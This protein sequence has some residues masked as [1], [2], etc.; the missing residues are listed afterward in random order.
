M[1]LALLMLFSAFTACDSSEQ[2]SSTE[3]AGSSETE[4]VLVT[5][6]ETETET[7]YFPN[8]A[9]NNYDADFFLSVQPDS[10]Y[11]EYHW[12]EESSNDVLSQAIYDRQQ[13]V[14][15]YLG[16]EI[17]GT[18]TETSKNYVDPFKIAVK[19]KD[20]SVDALLTHHYHGIDSFITGGFLSTF[21]SFSQIDLSGD[22]W[23]SEIMEDV[24]LNGKMYLGKSDFNILSTFVVAFNKE[25]MD[26][27]CDALPESVYSMVDNYRWTLDQMIALANMVY[28]DTTSDGHSIDD[29]FGVVA[30]HDAP[31]C[32]F[33][34]A[35]NVSMI[36]QNEQGDY[37]LS[38]YNDINKEK[39]TTIIEKIQGL[40]K[41]NSAWF[42]KWGSTEIVNFH[43]GKSLLCLSNT[44]NLPSYLNY[45]I[46]F[47][48]LPYPMYDETQKDIGYRSLQFGGFTCIPSYL[49]NPEM[50][51]DTMEMLSYFSE[52]VNVAFYEKLLGKQ[53]ADSPDDTR[54][55]EI[56][57][58]GIGTDFAQTFY[59]AFID[60]NI[61]HMMINLTYKDAT[62]NVASYIASKESTLNKK[63]DKFMTMVSKLT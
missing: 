63:I 41:S 58:E 5:D 17:V 37:V 7:E 1:I 21:N 12:V 34:L 51:G 62:M 45:D 40:A 8:V 16:V 27:Y 10:N 6:T 35:S 39:T 54:M 36:D 25:M 53:A 30:I 28:I 3:A 14:F 9:K 61:F 55:L 60:T 49:S 15:D 38:V 24:A 13:K 57:W 4:S 52:E 11:L 23:N 50:V 29:T 42:W 22:H 32:G 44:S 31:F 56:V 18:K 19:N 33:L 2:E 43:E 59:S 20:G 47:G 46:S 26:K 48:V